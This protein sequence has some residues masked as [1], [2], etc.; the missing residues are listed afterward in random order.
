LRLHIPPSSDELNAGD[1]VSLK[2]MLYPVPAQGFLPNL[3]QSQG[4]SGA[5]PT[6]RNA[7]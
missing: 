7:N 1:R 2:A 3:G 4:F 6:E 5:K